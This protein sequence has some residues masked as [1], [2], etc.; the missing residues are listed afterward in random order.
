MLRPVAKKSLQHTQKRLA[1][2]ALT[3]RL[4]LVGSLNLRTNQSLFS[5]ATI[6]DELRLSWRRKSLKLQ[7]LIES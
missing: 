1:T 4:V 2:E 6:C 7:S 5:V 3:R